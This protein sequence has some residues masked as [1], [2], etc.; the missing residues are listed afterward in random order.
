MRTQHFSQLPRSSLVLTRLQHERAH[1]EPEPALASADHDGRLGIPQQLRHLPRLQRDP[2]IPRDLHVGHV[3]GDVRNGKR[4]AHSRKLGQFLRN[5]L[6][7]T[8]P[9][10]SRDG[11]SNFHH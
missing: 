7:L 11:R 3:I 5:P 10:L 1:G 6:N 4:R 8:E 2:G 9:G